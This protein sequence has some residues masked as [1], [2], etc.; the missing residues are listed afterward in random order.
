[1]TNLL[2]TVDLLIF[3]G[4]NFRGLIKNYKF[5]DIEFQSLAKVCIQVYGKFVKQ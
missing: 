4:T 3:V 1:M 2:F 5:M